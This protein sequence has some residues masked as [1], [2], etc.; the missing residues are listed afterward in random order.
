[1]NDDINEYVPS[2]LNPRRF[3]R[4]DAD[5]SLTQNSI[6]SR[7]SLS[8]R[9]NNRH[10]L[11]EH[12]KLN[13]IPRDLTNK[14]N[15]QN[16]NNVPQNVLV[17]KVK[18]IVSKNDNCIDSI[19]YSAIDDLSTECDT[20]LINVQTN[21]NKETNCCIA[22]KS[23]ALHMNL[24]DAKSDKTVIY[25]VEKAIVA[26]SFGINDCSNIDFTT[27]TTAIKRINIDRRYEDVN[28]DCEIIENTE[29]S[30]DY[31]PDNTYATAPS[32]PKKVAINLEIKKKLS[33]EN[34]KVLILKSNA[35]E[36]ITNVTVQPPNYKLVKRKILDDKSKGTKRKPLTNNGNLSRDKLKQRSIDIFFPKVAGPREVRTT[37]VTNPVK[38]VARDVVDMSKNSGVADAVKERVA[39]SLKSGKRE[40]ESPRVPRVA[41]AKKELCKDVKTSSSEVPRAPSP[42][43][44]NESASSHSP[45]RNTESTQFSLPVKSKSNKSA[46]SPQS[47][48]QYKIVAGTHFAVD[49]FSYGEIPNVKHYF[50]THFHSDH[51]SGLKKSFNKLLF[52]SKI[53]ADLCMSRLGVNPKCIHVINVDETVRVEGVEVTAVDANHCPGAVMLIF[54]LPNGKSLLHTG[55]FRASP[56]MESYPIF[57]N[58]DIHT[59]YLDTTYCNPRYDFPTQDQSLEMA[60]YILRQK[61]LNLEKAGKKFSS[62]LIVC[63]TYTIGKEKF[64][65]GMARRVG[66]SVWAC[67]EKDRV[68]QAVEGRS[69]CHAPPH[70]CQLHVVP[71]RDLT[72]EKLRSYLDSLQGAF[73]EVVAFKP[74]GWE[75][76]KNS[77]V[78][79]DMVA[80]H[81]I[82]YSEHSSFSEL[83]RFV[84]YL[85]PKQVIPTVD[86][87]GGVKAV[88]KYFP[89]PLVYK[90]EAHCQSR[91]TDF[92]S[93]H[94]RHQV[95]VVS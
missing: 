79:R 52:C 5:V 40:N 93:M 10:S 37:N 45:R 60:L 61:K 95:P 66:C 8:L 80:I 27:K 82:P 62:V 25:D 48:P 56:T 43:V 22:P 6:V 18:Q 13:D 31:S 33:T 63:G 88:Q 44:K 70:A 16:T 81:G 2:L 47:I 1:M 15:V 11:F 17:P 28:V 3:K 49:A 29:P 36:K 46:I 69:F 76:G 21:F 57:W 54:T 71:M 73:N 85:K 68:L 83:I 55:D 9:R 32:P 72:H 58:K 92:F 91:M 86:I 26:V 84:K 35:I 34:L 67:P 51:Y 24:D 42:R 50:L 39:R 30:T 74:S 89:C 38:N 4:N 78:E 7:C 77:S 64:F 90:D 19:G 53:T 23:P 59:I 41:T 94:G 75:N 12:S 14:E 65:L 87:S 20:D